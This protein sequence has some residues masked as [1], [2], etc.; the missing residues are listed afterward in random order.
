MVKIK[1]GKKLYLLAQDKEKAK[2]LFD[3]FEYLE[4]RVQGLSDSFGG[5]IEQFAYSRDSKIKDF[6]GSIG[7]NFKLET[8]SLLKE[9]KS[10]KSDLSG[11]KTDL[12]GKIKASLNVLQ[13]LEAGFN[14]KLD[15]YIR[16]DKLSQTDKDKLVSE[17]KLSLNDAHTKI[18]QIKGFRLKVDGTDTAQVVNLIPGKGVNMTWDTQK[19]QTDIMI[20]AHPG[21]MGGSV[22]VGASKFT[23]LTDV[24]QTYAGQADR[25][26]T[27]KTD[28]TGLKFGM[29][30]TISDT[31]PSDPQLNDLWIDTS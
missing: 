20:T 10:V 16:E 7:N 13:S 17:I 14:G 25:L 5:S 23:Q 27:A 30:I 19:G 26:L 8:E 4:N 15:K 12:E 1:A 22:N 2:I 29:K 21:G 24:P 6:E 9:L 11:S 3:V 18:G 28:E 31:A